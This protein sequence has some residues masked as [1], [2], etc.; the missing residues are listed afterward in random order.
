MYEYEFLLM[1]V[2]VTETGQANAVTPV[3]VDTDAYYL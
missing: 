1:S 2:Y 3:A